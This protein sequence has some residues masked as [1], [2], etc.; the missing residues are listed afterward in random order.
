M[1]KSIEEGRNPTNGDCATPTRIKNYDAFNKILNENQ[2]YNFG[3]APN[4]IAVSQKSLQNFNPMS[5]S[6]I[7]N[8]YQWWFKK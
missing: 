3:Y 5:F 8:V 4:A 1:D 2:P 6:T 7:Y